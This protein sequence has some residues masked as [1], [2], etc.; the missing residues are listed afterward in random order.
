MERDQG[1]TRLKHA[2]PMPP[3]VSDR[4]DG[5]GHPV[6]RCSWPR[7]WACSACW[8]GAI[9]VGWP[10]HGHGSVEEASASCRSAP[11]DALHRLV[12]DRPFR[13]GHGEPGLLAADLPLRVV[14]PPTESI[15]WIALFSPAFHLNQLT[16]QV[17]G[18]P[19]VISLGPVTHVAA[20]V[21]V[22]CA[23]PV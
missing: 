18:V 8:C 13:A 3:G 10:A 9:A 17:G 22:T 16:L 14:L 20:L 11:S 4:Q 23:L 7:P 2:Q 15:R 12:R 21:G 6:Q 1:L 5:D 19:S